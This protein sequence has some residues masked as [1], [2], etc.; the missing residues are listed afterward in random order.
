VVV[1][2][3][4][5]LLCL[6]CQLWLLDVVGKERELQFLV[7]QNAWHRITE[8]Q[9]ETMKYRFHF[10]ET[11]TF[12]VHRPIICRRRTM[13]LLLQESS[14][15]TRT[16]IGRAAVSSLPPNSSFMLEVK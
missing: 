12:F 4:L 10:N 11:E 6:H 2:E 15:G 5:S 16:I 3:K 14:T 7:V 13:E 9:I 8:M 1:R